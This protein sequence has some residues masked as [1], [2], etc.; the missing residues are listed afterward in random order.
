MNCMHGVESM[1]S[2]IE[3]LINGYKLLQSGPHCKLGMDAVFLA[4]FLSASKT[5]RV[6]DLGCGGGAIA[7]LIAARYPTAE[8]DGVEIQPSASDL[9]EENIRL[10][11]VQHRVRSIRA[12]LCCLDDILPAGSYSAVVC[13]PPYFPVDSGKAGIRKE[14]Q[15]ERSELTADLQTICTVSA[16]LL[17]SGG[18]LGMVFR[19]ERLCDIVC[20]MRN[21]GIEPKRLKYIQ[22]EADTAPKLLLI[23]GRRNAS[24]GLKTEAPLM[25]RDRDGGFTD[26][27][28]RIYKGERI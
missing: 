2:K 15:I 13:N 14:R 19:A 22:N 26:E 16:W 7:M 20:S 4:A 23:S 6:C 8:I 24:P 11:A 5:A 12:D 1:D 3:D 9:L 21:A 27:Y 10:N 28:L 25:I 17:K 18:E